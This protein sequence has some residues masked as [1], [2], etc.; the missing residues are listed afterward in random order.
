MTLLHID[1]ENCGSLLRDNE[2]YDN[3]VLSGIFMFVKGSIEDLKSSPV[4]LMRIKYLTDIEDYVINK[5][6]QIRDE[7]RGV[8]SRNL[9]YGEF[10]LYRKI[11]GHLNSVDYSKPLRFIK[12]IKIYSILNPFLICVSLANPCH[13]CSFFALIAFPFNIRNL[14]GQGR[15]Q[16]VVP[17]FRFK[18][19]ETVFNHYFFSTTFC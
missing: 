1:Q 6:I 15:L 17:P 12:K 16:I 2:G 4:N 19:I 5:G 18:G 8:P 3:R 14:V 13:S 7:Q 11:N 9:L 10:T